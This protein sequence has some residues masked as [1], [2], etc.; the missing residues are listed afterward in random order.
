LRYQNEKLQLS[1]SYWFSQYRNDQN[2]FTWQNPY[3]LISGWQPNSGVGFRTGFGRMA[4]TPD[5]D[6]QQIQ[7][8]GGYNFTPTTRL[9]A[10]FQYGVARQN[11]AFLAQTINAPPPIP[12][13]RP[14]A[15]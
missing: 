9:T 13:S 3:A 1:L 4:L 6:V 12:P 11:D 8:T 10:T 7:A 15:E 5:N 14:T 2:S